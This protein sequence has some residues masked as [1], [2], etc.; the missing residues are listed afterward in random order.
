[1]LERAVDTVSTAQKDVVSIINKV[2]T[3]DFKGRFCRFYNTVLF[4]CLFY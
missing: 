2:L 4:K 3:F 1:M